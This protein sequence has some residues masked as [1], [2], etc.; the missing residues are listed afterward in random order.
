MDLLIIAGFLG[1][2]K[3]TLLS[4]IALSLISS[5]KKVA[6]I[7]NEAGKFGIDDLMLKE[8][9][10]EVKE[11]YS[12]C[13]CC[14]LRYDLITTMLELE[15]TVM[16]DVII[17]EPSGVAGPKQVLD[18][19]L[20]Y[21]GHIETKKVIVVV[22]APR[23]GALKNFSFPL[24]TD[25]I[26]AADLVIL[27]KVDLVNQFEL[28]SLNSKILAIRSDCRIIALCALNNTSHFE[29][30]E[31]LAF[32]KSAQEKPLE[33]HRPQNDIPHASVFSK[34]FMLAGTCE[35]SRTKLAERLSE[36]TA[37]IAQ[38]CSES[39]CSLVGHIK[40]IAKT[41][42]G[43]YLLVSSTGPDNPVQFQGKLPAEFRSLKIR[44][45]AIVYGIEYQELEQIMESRIAAF[46]SGFGCKSA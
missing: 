8:H 42:A 26:E 9:G 40:A 1:S 31:I 23:F 4:G 44:I 27:N 2:G 17:L 22:D 32:E 46:I 5:G 37:S 45:N 36:L 30:D 33:S 24:I 35:L 34:E 29:I 25:G 39:G 10:L 21:G 28:E 6:I 43:G 12:G 11:I 38:N 15:R 18:A 19:I 41:D 13:V 16:P 14:S 3:T 20:G 7:E